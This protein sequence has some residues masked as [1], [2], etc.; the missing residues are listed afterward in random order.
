MFQM[1]LGMLM[2][3]AKRQIVATGLCFSFAIH[4]RD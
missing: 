3:L 2:R 4:E 1:A